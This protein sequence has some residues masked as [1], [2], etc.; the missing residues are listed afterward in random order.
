[1]QIKCLLR[2]FPLTTAHAHLSSLYFSTQLTKKYST[3]MCCLPW[4][5]LEARSRGEV[6]SQKIF[7]V[8]GDPL[9]CVISCKIFSNPQYSIWVVIAELPYIHSCSSARIYY[10]Q[11]D[12]KCIISEVPLAKR[13][14]RGRARRSR[15]CQP[16]SGMKYVMGGI[17]QFLILVF[18]RNSIS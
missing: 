13:P 14:F 18:R 4:N 2:G 3:A 8:E 16:S 7:F 5:T 15:L 12:S 1:M 17:A 11:T 6:V 10:W 9:I